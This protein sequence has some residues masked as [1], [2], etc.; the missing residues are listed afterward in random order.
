MALPVICKQVWLYR[1]VLC[2]PLPS[3]TLLVARNMPAFSM[4]SLHKLYDVSHACTEK[5]KTA[6]IF[7][8]TTYGL[9]SDSYL[10]TVKAPPWQRSSHCELTPIFGS[11]QTYCVVHHCCY[12]VFRFKNAKP[13]NELQAWR[14]QGD[15]CSGDRTSCPVTERL[16]VWNLAG[17]ARHFSHF[18][19]N[20]CELMFRRVTTKWLF[21]ADWQPRFCQAIPGQLWVHV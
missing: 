20:K 1:S 12:T 13:T 4:Q 18:A 3:L 21:G 14:I 9:S 17:P 6:N 5:K 15:C 10:W 11:D 19:S 8:S 2:K 7:V 16:A